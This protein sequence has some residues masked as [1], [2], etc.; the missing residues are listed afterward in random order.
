MRPM[1]TS[2]PRPRYQLAIEALVL[3]TAD[4]AQVAR[5]LPEQQRICA[6]CREVRS[7]AEASAVLAIP[8][9][10]VRILVADLA[11]AGLVTIHQPHS[12]TSTDTRPD[13]AL[14]ARVLHA[15]RGD[16]ALALLP[17]NT[18]SL[19]QPTQA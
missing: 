11:E 5:Q 9:G 14:L 15:L 1:T 10:V 7:V 8:L 6:L 13:T 2:P 18:A 17:Q 3:T 16:S 4:A 12:H 19:L